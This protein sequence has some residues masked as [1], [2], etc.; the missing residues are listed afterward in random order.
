VVAVG[1]GAIGLW[2]SFKGSS[3]AWLAI[4]VLMFLGPPRV[5]TS[6]LSFIL[7]AVVIILEERSTTGLANA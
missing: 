4:A 1:I 2:L 6:Y 5:T 7:V 3:W